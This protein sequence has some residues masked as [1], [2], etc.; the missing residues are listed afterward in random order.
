MT[1]GMENN[2]LCPFVTLA[3]LPYIYLW[4]SVLIHIGSVQLIM[5]YG[6]FQPLFSP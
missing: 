3:V 5:S 1:R 2:G 4:I 6:I